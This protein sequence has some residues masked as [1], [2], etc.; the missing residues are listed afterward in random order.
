MHALMRLAYTNNPSTGTQEFSA[1][2][3]YKLSSRPAGHN[4]DKAGS[5]TLGL[6]NS[7]WQNMM[8]WL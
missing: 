8:I 4:G 7:Q 1:I 2:L 5:W 6:F 3:N